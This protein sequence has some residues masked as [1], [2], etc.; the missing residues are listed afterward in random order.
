MDTAMI[1]VLFFASLKETTG[2]DSLSV[3]LSDVK[4]SKLIEKI[5]SDHPTWSEALTAPNIVVSVNKEIVLDD[6]LISQGDEVAFL[7]PVTGG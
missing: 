5:I 3:M 7:P 4:L 6:I 1:N 2:Q